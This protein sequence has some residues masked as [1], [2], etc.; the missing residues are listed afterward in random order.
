MLSAVTRESDHNITLRG[1]RAWFA[2]YAVASGTEGVAVRR[3]ALGESERTVMDILR[4]AARVD[5]ANAA[6]ASY[7]D[8]S[9][10]DASYSDA[11]HAVGGQ[12]AE[13]EIH[14][15][16]T[17]ITLLETERAALWWAVGHDELTGLANRRLLFSL[18]PPVLRDWARRAAVVVLDLNGFKPINDQL[19]HA[20][21][22]EVLKVV[23]ERLSCCTGADLAARLGGDEFAVIIT[24]P[25]A[26]QRHGWWQRHAETLSQTIAEPMAVAGHTVRVT[27]SI[28]IAPV[29]AE[30]PIDELLHCADQAMYEAKQSGRDFV[31]WGTQ[32]AVTRRPETV[33]ELSLF[34]D[35]GVETRIET[36]GFPLG[37]AA[38]AAA[39]RQQAQVTLPTC[40]PCHRDPSDVA[41]AETYHHGDR[42]WVHRYAAWRPGIVESASSRAVL[43]TYRCNEGRGT[44]VDTVYAEY[45]MSRSH[46]DAQ[47]DDSDA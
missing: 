42:V 27:A 23:A 43:A 12:A 33:V 31:A 25:H 11:S 35:G 15:L 2:R 20:A 29:H 4:H 28:G 36:Y 6:D 24:D 7:S 44:V 37:R 18:A 26:E 3:S 5:R 8:A 38:R 19:G 46:P 22:D 17:Q 40:E 30:G 10:S 14:R 1:R 9:Y 16:K 32:P 21:G 47:L 34:A 39:Q 13:A 45:V 41:P